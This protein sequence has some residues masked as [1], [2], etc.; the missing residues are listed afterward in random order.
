M[1]DRFQRQAGLVPHERLVDLHCTVIGVGA[2]GRQVALQLAS[3]GVR[4]LQLIDFD[5]VE[6]TNITTQGYLRQD[7]GLHKVEATQVAVREI[8]PTIQVE[9]IPDRFRPS[10]EVG[11]AVFCCVDAIAAREVIWRHRA[12]QIRFWC[13]GR[14]LGEVMRILTV[15]DPAED[16]WYSGTL[17][18]QEEAEQGVCTSR[19]VIYNAA[20]AAGLMLHQFTRW[21]RRIPV[22]REVSLNLLSS[23]WSV[24]GPELSPKQEVNSP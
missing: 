5:R 12:E 16:L 10:Q 18:R 7:L 24:S 6:E 11:D 15:T 13:D 17:F 14:M 3:L 2:V 21:L 22:D 4:H 1:N 20:I 19:G 23:E 9:A 8:D